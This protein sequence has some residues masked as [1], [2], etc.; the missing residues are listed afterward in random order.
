MQRT[1]RNY[2]GRRKDGYVQATHRPIN[3]L[4]FLLPLIVAYEIGSW[5]A[6]DLPI[7]ASPPE[8]VI[9]FYWIV[10]FL[11]LFATVPTYLP[12]LL[13]LIVLAVWH[14]VSEQRGRFRWQTVLGMAVESFLFCLPLLVLSRLLPAYMLAATAPTVGGLGMREQLVVALTAGIYEELIFRLLLFWMFK[15]LL[16]DILELPHGG[17]I[18]ATVLISAALFGAY[19]YLGPEQFSWHTF[20]F[21]TSAG[22]FLGMIYVLRGFG[23][24]VG[25]HALYDVIITLWSA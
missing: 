22:V 16:V 13:L 17:S 8:R 21:R 4:A 15:L 20:L 18:I 2:F 5:T 6:G 3:C 12:G 25:T 24:T 11:G 23:I 19:H 1:S 14:L 7:S 9:A 10:R